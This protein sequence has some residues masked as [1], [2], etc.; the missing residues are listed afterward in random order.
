MTTIEKYIIETEADRVIEEAQ[1]L[2][3]FPEENKEII[4]LF[5]RIDNSKES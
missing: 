5:T 4:S 1:H 2:L 3:T